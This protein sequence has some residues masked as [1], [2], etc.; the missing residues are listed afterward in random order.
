M[1]CF[2]SYALPSLSLKESSFS[3]I[4]LGVLLSML[5]APITWAQAP[6]GTISGTITDPTGAVIKD[7]PISVRNKATGFER[8]TKSEND[9]TYSAPALPAG[10]YEVQA[11][12]QGFRTILREVTVTVGSIIKLDLVL[13]VAPTTEIVTVD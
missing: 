4:A 6:V 10:Q 11:Q 2:A 3:R 9:G 1:R 7:A 13:E 8:R 12:V 5:I